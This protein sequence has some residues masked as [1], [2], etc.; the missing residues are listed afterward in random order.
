MFGKNYKDE[1]F[2]DIKKY[3]EYKRRK[4]EALIKGTA[5]FLGS[6]ILKFYIILSTSFLLF[7]IVTNFFD[8]NETLVVIVTFILS[9]QILKIDYVKIYPFKSL[10]T[11]WFLIFLVFIAF[12]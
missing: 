6:F 2:E 11:L 5:S 10:A 12:Y 3:E 7:S 9:F 1:D 8:F 4:D